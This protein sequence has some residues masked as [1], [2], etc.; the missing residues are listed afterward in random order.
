MT[1]PPPPP[2]DIEMVNKMK[3]PGPKDCLIISLWL[4]V[5]VS[6]WKLNRCEALKCK[7]VCLWVYNS[8][9]TLS[10][11]PW[12]EFGVQIPSCIPHRVLFNLLILLKWVELQGKT[13]IRQKKFIFRTRVS[14]PYQDSTLSHQDPIV[15][16][17]PFHFQSLQVLNFDLFADPDPDPVSKN[18]AD[19]D[20]QPRSGVSHEIYCKPCLAAL[21][22]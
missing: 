21:K 16:V 10:S 19:P 6:W 15:N 4:F 8:E 7:C 13:K 14:D 9:S 12:N 22:G 11:H 2:T 1:P 3:A 5:N 18:I 17:G 20:P